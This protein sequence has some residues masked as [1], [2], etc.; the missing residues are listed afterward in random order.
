MQHIKVQL[1]M[2][3][4]D[5]TEQATSGHLGQSLMAPH[6]NNRSSL[7]SLGSVVPADFRFEAFA[8]SK[9]LVDR[10]NSQETSG[11]GKTSIR[12]AE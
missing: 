5:A 1:K 12:H 8:S 10:L 4:Q 6:V 11:T 3:L 7:I 9:Q 2:R